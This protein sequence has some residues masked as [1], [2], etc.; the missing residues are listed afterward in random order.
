MENLKRSGRGKISLEV[1][2]VPSEGNKPVGNPCAFAAERT[3]LT[4][5]CIDELFHEK[6]KIR[7]TSLSETYIRK[8]H[9]INKKI[10]SRITN[11]AKFIAS[12]LLY[13]SSLKIL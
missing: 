9:S 2:S 5:S 8:Y 1:P 6:D 13:L 7:K 11:R 12:K 3:F 4:F 10:P